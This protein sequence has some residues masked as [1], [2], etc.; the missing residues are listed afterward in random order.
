MSLINSSWSPL[1]LIDLVLAS[2]STFAT[3]L[4]LSLW[5]CHFHASHCK[6]EHTREADDLSRFNLSLSNNLKLP[7][8]VRSES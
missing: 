3:E 1:D 2:D 8:K 7:N 4:L 6:T 5:L